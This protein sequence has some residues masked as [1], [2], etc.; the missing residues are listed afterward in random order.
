M[1]SRVRIDIAFLGLTERNMASD[2]REDFLAMMGSALK[3]TAQRHSHYSFSPEFRCRD[4]KER[5]LR[6]HCD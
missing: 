6:G 2:Y 4:I 3:S 5:F 1:I